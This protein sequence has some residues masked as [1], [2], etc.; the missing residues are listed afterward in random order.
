MSTEACV[1]VPPFAGRITARPE[2]ICP[3]APR[4]RRAGSR[5]RILII[6]AGLSGAYLAKRLLQQSPTLDLRVIDEGD[7]PGGRML[8]RR[9]PDDNWT[10]DFGAARFN[11]QQHPRLARLVHALRLPV[12]PFPRNGGSLHLREPHRG[13]IPD[14][15]HKALT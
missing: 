5:N 9:L 12:A 2:S 8:S 10:L 4:T 6:G 3:G 15:L 7:E 14:L 1:F 13:R 11:R